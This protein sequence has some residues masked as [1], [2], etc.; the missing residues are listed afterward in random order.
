[1]SKLRKNK[2]RI[3]FRRF[4]KELKLESD[5]VQAGFWYTIYS[6]SGLSFEEW[7]D[8]GEIRKK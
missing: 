7:N 3:S 2:R 6:W 8:G 1:V 5:P 4:I